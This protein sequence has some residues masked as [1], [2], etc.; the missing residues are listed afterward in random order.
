[1][2]NQEVAS[3]YNKIIDSEYD[4]DYEFWR[5]SKNI[6]TFIDYKMTYLS[7]LFHTRNLQFSD[8]I[9]VGPGPGTWTQLIYGHHSDASFTLVDISEAMHQQ[10][11]KSMRESS[12]VNYLVGDITNFKSEKKHDF[13]FSG[14]SIEYWDDVEGALSNI[15]T[16]LEGGA[17]GVILT[18]NPRYFRFRKFMGRKKNM[19]EGDI[20]AQYLVKLLSQ[21]GFEDIKVYPCVYRTPIL[22]RVSTSVSEILFNNNYRQETQKLSRFCESY[23]VVFKKAT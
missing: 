18:K 16:L 10:F 21:T 7:L 14:R 3:T 23:V 20:D 12:N 9:E 8:M 15:V 4:A 6:R 22:D 1:M 11:R 13:F 19:H 5:W 2:K 17:T